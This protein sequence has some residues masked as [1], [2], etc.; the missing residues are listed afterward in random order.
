M[1]HANTLLTSLECLHRDSIKH[2]N[3]TEDNQN[4]I[5]G[6]KYRTLMCKLIFKQESKLIFL[7]TNCKALKQLSVYETHFLILFCTSF[8]LKHE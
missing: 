1:N 3:Y 6:K 4:H 7:K 8:V 5:R 2:L